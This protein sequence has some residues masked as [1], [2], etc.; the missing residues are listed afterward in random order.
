MMMENLVSSC[1][2]HFSEKQLPSC[3]LST[4]M[5]E[6]TGNR[7]PGVKEYSAIAGRLGLGLL[8]LEGEALGFGC[9]PGTRPQQSTLPW[10]WAMTGSGR[11]GS[12]N[13]QSLRFW[14]RPRLFGRR[15]LL[16]MAAAGKSLPNVKD[17]AGACSYARAH[18]FR[19]YI[20]SGI[21]R[22]ARSSST[23]VRAIASR[24]LTAVLS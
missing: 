20:L 22:G 9:S 19:A 15:L 17:L 8:G 1:L 24:A 7:G 18:G 3:F 13:V 21:A 4:R 12:P 6:C 2:G 10:P 5:D 23:K 14:G 11:N 16:A